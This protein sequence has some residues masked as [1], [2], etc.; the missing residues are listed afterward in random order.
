MYITKFLPF[1]VFQQFTAGGRGE[2]ILA[3]LFCNMQLQQDIDDAAVPGRL[4]VDLL[5]QLQRING[6]YHRNV[7]SDILYLV[8]LEM[9]DEMPLDVL[10]QT[11]HLPCKLLFLALA[12]DTL[13]LTVG[14]LDIFDRMELADGNQPHTIRKTP[15]HFA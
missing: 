5:Q 2:A 10:R 3:L 15:K 4:F 9:T 13:A 8:R 6:L 1:T 11:L 14:S 12:E 7:R